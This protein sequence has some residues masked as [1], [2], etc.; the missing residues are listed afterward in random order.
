[1]GIVLVN[2][3]DVCL[4]EVGF[5]D[6][7]ETKIRPVL[8]LGKEAFLLDCMVMTSQPPRLGEYELQYWQFIVY[9]L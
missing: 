3:W 1:M 9:S 6:I 8:I 4:A 7:F 2:R 5:D